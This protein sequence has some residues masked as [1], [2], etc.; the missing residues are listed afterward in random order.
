M[1]Y[2]NFITELSKFIENNSKYN[3]LKKELTYLA[4]LES[5][6]KQDAS[7]KSSSAIGWF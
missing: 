7:A 1:N 4:K 3:H 5:D 6:F 2:S